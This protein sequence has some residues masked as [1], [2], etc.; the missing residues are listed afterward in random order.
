MNLVR[1]RD[2]RENTASDLR[3]LDLALGGIES[4]KALLALP[5]LIKKERNRD[6]LPDD[7]F[8]IPAP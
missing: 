2:Q 5:E 4:M 8:G 6:P 1:L 7:N 3:K